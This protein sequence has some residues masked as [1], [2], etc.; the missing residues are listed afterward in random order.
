MN[1]EDIERI[2]VVYGDR[3]AIEQFLEVND[4]AINEAVVT[5][6]DLLETD[7]DTERFKEVKRDICK[8]GD[9]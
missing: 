8:G 2:C 3:E 9:E 4:Q 6:I 1:E 7:P 5:K